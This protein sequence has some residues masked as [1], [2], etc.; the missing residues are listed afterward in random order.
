MKGKSYEIEKEK[1]APTI[2]G[3][4]P[5]LGACG[6]AFLDFPGGRARFRTIRVPSVLE[7]TA[8]VRKIVDEITTFCPRLPDV[9]C[10]EEMQVYR[11]GKQKGDPNDLIKLAFLSGSVVDRFRCRKIYLPKP[12]TW[13]G[14]VPKNIHHA[15]LREQNPWI[16]PRISSDA[17]DAIGLAL[18]A[19]RKEDHANTQERP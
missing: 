1:K 14:Q 18:W 7:F 12:T 10:I 13:K 19:K 5:G 3:V 9:L 11:Q 15:R 2:L 17:M 16:P 6:L 4:D 8:R